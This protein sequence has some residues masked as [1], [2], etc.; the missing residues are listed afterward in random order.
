[1]Q[2]IRRLFRFHKKLPSIPFVP[3]KALLYDFVPFPT[4]GVEVSASLIPIPTLRPTAFSL[5][6]NQSENTSTWSLQQVILTGRVSTR[7]RWACNLR[8]SDITSE[9]L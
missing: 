9:I 1:M 3:P 5:G 8:L 6:E 7:P 4:G 2:P